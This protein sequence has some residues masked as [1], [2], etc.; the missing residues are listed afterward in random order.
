LQP[1]QIDLVRE[2]RKLNLI[3]NITD[4][5]VVILDETRKPIF[6]KNV[7]TNEL[8]IELDR[9]KYTL[10]VT[11]DNYKRVSEAVD[12]RY[13]SAESRIKMVSEFENFIYRTYLLVGTPNDD[14]YTGSSFGLRIDYGRKSNIY[15]NII[16]R[17]INNI[18]Y[19]EDNE[20]HF[21]STLGYSKYIFYNNSNALNIHFGY[22][23]E[24]DT[25]DNALIDI[26]LTFR[27]TRLSFLIGYQMSSVTL[28]NFGIG[29]SF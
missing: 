21:I 1:I 19:P 9:G 13:E 4:V 11:K 17:T 20:T 10:E 22:G 5:E 18:E 29:F 14:Y 28:I 25:P 16:Y 24:L 23:N 2:K 12:L 3:F 27:Y 26:G 7:E 15:L 8:S 6:Q